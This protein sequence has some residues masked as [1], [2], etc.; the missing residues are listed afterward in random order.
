MEVVLALLLAAA[1]A[2]EWL[3]KGLAALKA[4]QVVEARAA[5][6]EAVKLAPGEPVIWLAAA[7]A[8]LRSGDAEG[9]LAAVGRASL[10]APGAPVVVRGREMFARRVGDAGQQLLDTR[11]EKQAEA[12]LRAAVGVFGREAE[13]WR[14]L[15]LS[16]YAQGR[17]GEAVGAFVAAIDLAPE[18]EMLYAGLETLLPAGR[19]VERRLAS[20]VSRHPRSAL[21]WYLLGLERGEPALWE[22]S[23]QLDGQFW[24]AAFALHRHVEAGRAVELLERVV[25]LNPDYGPAYFALAQFYGKRGDR[26]KAQAARRRHYE[27]V[28][29][30]R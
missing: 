6:E 17:N 21:G 7:D 22:R 3:Q 28:K 26:E 9:A 25:A 30:E 8:R 1:G 13:L 12:L 2:E 5:L 4:G 11:R 14:L 19:E 29:R 16:L 23:W 15:G 10:L 20:Y 27:I 24:P 18:A